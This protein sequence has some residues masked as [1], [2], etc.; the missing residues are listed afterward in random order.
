MSLFLAAL[1]ILLLGGALGWLFLHDPGY[2]L[3]AWQQVSVEMSLTLAVL[4]LVLA[5]VSGLVLLELLLGVFGLRR[6]LLHW[7][8][9]HKARRA[10]RLLADGLSWL[11]RGD[12]ARG[13]K[14]LLQSA[15]LSAHPLTAAWLASDSAC[16]RHEYRLAEDYL[17][18]AA[19]HSDHLPLEL[20]RVRIWLAAGQWEAASA[21]L[22]NLYAHYRKEQA[23]AELL[24]DAL[25]R[26]QAW[27]ELA[28]WLPKLEG[29]LGKERAVSLG[30]QGHGQVMRWMA[31]TG[32]RID[33][34]AALRQL[35]TYWLDIPAALRENPEL[36][37]AYAESMLAQGFEDE[38]EPLVRE[39]LNRNWH[40][41]LVALYG[42][43]RSSR[44]EE[45][46][47]QAR[48]WLAAHPRN[49]LLLLTMAR[50]SLQN[51]DWDAA[52]A[53]LEQSLSLSKNTETYAEYVRLLQHLQDPER[54]H[55]LVAGLQQLTVRPLPSLPLP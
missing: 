55:Y 16:R 21:R 46:L 49:P 40:N 50:L 13:E 23:L 29:L 24:V 45:A 6:L 36:V 5:A 19:G 11:Q 26:L 28:E 4:L 43:I 8:R 22:K 53:F 14:L 15:G 20:A 25:C 9:Q 10:E 42:R 41:G 30:V 38:A 12:H 32:N 39:F 37:E 48:L 54:E 33:R 17:D 51:R 3:I 44:P 47:R 2:V 7:S 31:K 35:R 52:R 27:Q 18:L 34:A 1:A